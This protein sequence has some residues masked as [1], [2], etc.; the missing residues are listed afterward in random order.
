MCSAIGPQRVSAF[1][2][3][4]SSNL[5]VFVLSVSLRGKPILVIIFSS[6]LV[7]EGTQQL[8]YFRRFSAHFAM[9]LFAVTF[10][11][12]SCEVSLR[13][14]GSISRGPLIGCSLFQI[15]AFKH[16]IRCGICAFA[17]MCFI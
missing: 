15:I 14:I 10:F 5:P 9:L 12:S 3:F 11:I 16:I 8:S 7:H 4:L 17:S 13:L 6:S 1:L 2:F